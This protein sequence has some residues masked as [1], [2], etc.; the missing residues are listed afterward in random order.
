[1]YAGVATSK[2]FRIFKFSTSS[3]TDELLIREAETF[4][5]YEE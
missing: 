1:M 3:A 5:Y 4:P 2:G